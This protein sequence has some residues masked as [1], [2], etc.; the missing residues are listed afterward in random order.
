MT[1]IWLPRLTLIGQI[2][3]LVVLGVLVGI[4]K[5]STILD[6]LLAV[7]GSL[8]GVGLF[9]TVSKKTTQPTQP[10]QPPPA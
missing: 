6:A 8:T 10:T 4:G 3:V 7:S 9:Q 1:D 5:D 2:A